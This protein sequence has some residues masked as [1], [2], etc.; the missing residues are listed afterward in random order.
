[1]KAAGMLEARTDLAALTQRAFMPL[2]GV[3]DE[4]LKGVQVD[5]VAGGQLPPD[6]DFMKVAAA[7][8]ME[9]VPP[10]CAPGHP[11]A[12]QSIVPDTRYAGLEG[13]PKFDPAA[14]SVFSGPRRMEK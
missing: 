3:S 1:M 2:D 7:T 8:P 6:F 9:K 5:S 12:F 4:W 10:C 11:E 13:T 14:E